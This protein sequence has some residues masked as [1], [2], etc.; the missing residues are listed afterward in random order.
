MFVDSVNRNEPPTL[1]HEPEYTNVMPT[2]NQEQLLW[3]PFRAAVTIS[4]VSKSSTYSASRSSSTLFPSTMEAVPTRQLSSPKT[5][6]PFPFVPAT[7]TSEV[8]DLNNAAVYF[9]QRGEPRQSV[10]Y[11]RHAVCLLKRQCETQIQRTHGENL[12]ATIHAANGYAF[13]NQG[14]ED[15]DD[16]GCN[17]NPLRDGPTPAGQE[18]EDSGAQPLVESV[19][20]CMDD[21]EHDD[22]CT[23]FYRRALVLTP[24]Q[25]HG[26]S[27]GARCQGI[28]MAVIMYNIALVNH[29]LA[30]EATTTREFRQCGEGD[31]LSTAALRMYSVA[32]AALQSREYSTSGCWDVRPGEHLVR[33]AIYTNTAA[34]HSNFYDVLSMERAL[35]N[36]RHVIRQMQSGFSASADFSYADDAVVVGHPQE[37]EGAGSAF[38]SVDIDVGTENSDMYGS[39]VSPEDYAFFCLVDMLGPSAYASAAAMA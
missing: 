1:R 32:L 27:I 33:L 29:C 4:K 9:L 39:S 15:G 35:L 28:I 16:I 3:S 26:S 14:S 12:K 2:T 6:P 18:A 36:V 19:R 8:C 34:I 37:D 13:D 20:V 5:P 22:S 23:L 30:I 7:T 24:T 38:E 31:R 10:E 25:R 21:D 17:S 11:L